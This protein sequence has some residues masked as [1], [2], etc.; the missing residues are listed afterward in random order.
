[1][2]VSSR[3]KKVHLRSSVKKSWAKGD[4]TRQRRLTNIIGQERRKGSEGKRL[5]HKAVVMR[6]WLSE[7]TNEREDS[8]L[9]KGQDVYGGSTIS[10]LPHLSHVHV[11][12]RDDLEEIYERCGVRCHPHAR[13]TL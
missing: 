6:L 12:S 10:L 1:M 8:P 2:D 13:A 7:L 4:M 5:S 11:S 3:E 9:E